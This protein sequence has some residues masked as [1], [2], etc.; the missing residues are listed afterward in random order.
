MV[1]GRDVRFI[2]QLGIANDGAGADAAALADLG[3][4]R[5]CANGSM[6]V[7]MPMRA[8]TSIVTVS[9]FSMVTPSSINSRTFALAE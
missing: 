5:I 1:N 3:A 6:T 8:C 4:P 2:G 9:G 7:S